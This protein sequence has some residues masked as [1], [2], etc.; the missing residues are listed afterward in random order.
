MECKLVDE[1]KQQCAWKAR[2]S[3]H[4]IKTTAKKLAT[5]HYSNKDFKA[6]NGWFFQFLLRFN[7]KF[8]K[9]KIQKAVSAEE[10]RAKLKEWHKKLWYEVLSYRNGHKGSYDGMFGRFPPDR[11]NSFY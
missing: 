8:R 1:L 2:V 9:R 5:E 4:C 6:S 10:K 3:E 11:S 7:I